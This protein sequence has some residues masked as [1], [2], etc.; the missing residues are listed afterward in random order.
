M[1]RAKNR[2]RLDKTDEWVVIVPRGTETSRASVVQQAHGS[3]ALRSVNFL[4]QR[5]SELHKSTQTLTFVL[6]T[7]SILHNDIVLH[8]PPHDHCSLTWSIK[9]HE[10]VSDN[11]WH[12]DIDHWS[13]ITGPAC[14]Q[15]TGSDLASADFTLCERLPAQ[16][17]STNKTKSSASLHMCFHATSLFCIISFLILNCQNIVKTSADLST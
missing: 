4:T 3:R 17:R 12:T 16:S 10:I 6:L 2:E 8:Q 13:L 1:K 5:C 14:A 15:P 7:L 9:T 11:S